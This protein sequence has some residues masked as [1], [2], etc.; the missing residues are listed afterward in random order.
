M[1]YISKEL[2]REIARSR[3][4]LYKHRRKSKVMVIDNYGEMKSGSYLRILTYFFSTVTLVFGLSI[5]GFYP[6][7]N[8]QARS[9]DELTQKVTILEQKTKNLAQEKN[10]YMARLVIS[11]PKKIAPRVVDVPKAKR[12]AKVK[13]KKS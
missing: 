9:F 8:H 7:Y 5:A 4:T 10:I 1:E 6:L 13:E 12:P 3:P 2:K 11:N